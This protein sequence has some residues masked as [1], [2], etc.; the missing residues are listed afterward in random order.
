[1]RLSRPFFQLPVLFDSARLAAE[2]A[3]LPEA[4][5]APHPD[6]LPGNTAVRLI[7][8]DSAETDIHHGQM[9]PTPWLKAMP[10]AQQVL[11]GFGVVW[12]GSA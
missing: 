6:R 2:V 7:T 10:Y 12:E 9:L 5:W 4:A 11:A 1:M 8:V 3:A